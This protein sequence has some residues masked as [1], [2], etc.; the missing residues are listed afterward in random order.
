M[1]V[2]MLY[3]KYCESHKQKER[4]QS[5]RTMGIPIA[6]ITINLKTKVNTCIIIYYLSLNTSLAACTV[7]MNNSAIHT[8]PNIHQFIQFISPAINPPKQYSI[9][10]TISTEKMLIKLSI[11]FV[12]NF[13]LYKYTH[14]LIN[15]KK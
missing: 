6:I 12:L 11:K 1:I 8:R 9:A 3:S 2:S 5:K 14:Y 13:Q 15:S 10:S 7:S 4:V